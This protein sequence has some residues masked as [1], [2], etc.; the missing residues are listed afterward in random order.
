MNKRCTRPLH[1]A[2]YLNIQHIPVLNI[3]SCIYLLPVLFRKRLQ[4]VFYFCSIFKS[5][6]SIVSPSEKCFYTRFF[7]LN[8]FFQWVGYLNVNSISGRMEQDES[9]IGY[10]GLPSKDYGAES[11]LAEQNSSSIGKVHQAPSSSVW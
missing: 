1:I 5:H 6:D 10:L 8:L 3:M 2:Q 7:W 4:L 11:Y 9:S